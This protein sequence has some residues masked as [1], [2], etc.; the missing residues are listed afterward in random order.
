MEKS[1]GLNEKVSW[2]CKR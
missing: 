2:I 1:Y